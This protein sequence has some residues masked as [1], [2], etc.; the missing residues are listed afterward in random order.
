MYCTACAS[1]NSISHKQVQGNGSCVLIQTHQAI[2]YHEDSIPIIEF[3]LLAVADHT[4]DYD[5]RST[6]TDAMQLL[7]SIEYANYVDFCK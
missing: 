2:N 1:Q 6:C 3:L 5:S 4:P 7:F